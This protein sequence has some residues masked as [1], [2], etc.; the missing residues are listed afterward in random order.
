MITKTEIKVMATLTNEFGETMTVAMRVRR[1]KRGLFKEEIE[2]QIMNTI[3]L[4]GIGVR[5]INVKINEN[6]RRHSL[7]DNFILS[8]L[9]CNN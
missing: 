4:N 8:G 6:N 5:I 3:N 2:N 1:A 9:S 7:A